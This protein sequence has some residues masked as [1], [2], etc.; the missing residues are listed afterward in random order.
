[1]IENRQTACFLS[2]KLTFLS[3]I[4][5][6]LQEKQEN[7]AISNPINAR[8]LIKLLAYLLATYSFLAIGD[9]C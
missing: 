5:G 4:M 6:S 7:H 1:M 8:S 9:F 2:L 3:S